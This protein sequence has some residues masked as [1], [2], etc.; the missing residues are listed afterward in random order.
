MMKS[1]TIFDNFRQISRVSCRGNLSNGHTIANTT[2]NI[3]NSNIGNNTDNIG[4]TN[5]DVIDGD[6][7]EIKR[8]SASDHL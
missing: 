5:D 6:E 1:R 8:R 3:D 2:N 7:V 4:N